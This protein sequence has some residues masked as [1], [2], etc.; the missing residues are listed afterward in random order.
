MATAQSGPTARALGGFLAL[1]GAGVMAGMVWA[2]WIT[3]RGESVTGWDLQ[4]AAAGSEQWY[5]ERFFD[6]DFSPF[7]PGRTVLAAAAVIALFG[8]AVLLARKGVR[9]GT[10]A[11]MMLGGLTALAVGVVD[12]LTIALTGPGPEILYIDWGLLGVGGGGV[13]ALLGLML[14][15]TQPRR[16]PGTAGF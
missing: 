16:I 2:P 9:G 14:A 8:L 12:V 1:V 6:P 3:G 7:F 10:R 11:L 5:I 13:I 4:Q 15:T